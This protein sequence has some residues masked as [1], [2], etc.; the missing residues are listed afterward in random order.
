MGSYDKTKANK[1]FNYTSHFSL[2]ISASLVH[3][4]FTS[5]VQSINLVLYAQII[6]SSIFILMFNKI[7]L[8]YSCVSSRDP[9]FSTCKYSDNSVLCWKYSVCLP[10]KKQ[11]FRCVPTTKM[12]N[13]QQESSSSTAERAIS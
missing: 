1:K 9:T 13:Y 7:C 10:K 11:C 12:T 3:G 6:R 5:Y 8:S 2:L 4:T